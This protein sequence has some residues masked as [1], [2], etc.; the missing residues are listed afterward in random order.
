MAIANSPMYQD[1]TMV[2]G[3]PLDT[4]KVKGQPAAETQEELKRTDPQVQ[5]Q[6]YLEQRITYAQEVRDRNWP[7]FSNKT[8][9]Q[10]YQDNEKIANTYVEPKKNLDEVSLASGTIESKLGTLLSHIDNLNL[11]PEVLA[12]DR[13]DKPLRDLGVAFTD[14]LDKVAEH[15]GGTDGGDSEKRL[16]RQKDLLKQGTVFVQD[17]WC[18]KR[19]AQKTLKAKYKGEFNWDAWDTAWK[20]YYEGPD[21]VLLYGPNVYLGD[22]T[23]FS[24]D[25]QP[26]VFTVETMSYDIARTLFGTF[27][28]WT[29]VKQGM[30]PST[31]TTAA[32]TIGGRTIYDGKFRLTTLKDTQVEVIKYQDPTRDEFQ[33]MINGVMMLPIGFPLS[34]VTPGGKINIAKQILFPINPQFA[35]GK[36]FVASG[37][38]YGLSRQ[39]DEFI[40]L[41]VM[42]TRK[43]ITPAY[44]NMTSKVIS[45]RV[46]SPGN[47]SQ[48]IPPNALLPINGNETQ[49]VTN[50]EFAVYKQMLELM[51]KS[52]I[53]P[54]FQGQYGGSNT[55]ATEVI[56]VQRQARLSIG[57]IITACTLL[58]VKLT[59]LRLP[60]IIAN[61]FEPLEQ[62]MGEDGAT[63]T[64][65]Y[66]STSRETDIEGSGK[67]TRQ[68]IPMD[69]ELPSKQEVRGLE[70]MEEQENGYPVQ[71]IFLSPKQLRKIE[72]TWYV[73]VRP[74]ER[75]KSAY[76]KLLFR[77]MLADGIA[78]FKLGSV[79]NLQGLETQF[80]N[81]YSKDRNSFFGSP[82]DL[83]SPT[84]P[85]SEGNAGGME[86]LGSPS[87]G[88]P[89]A[90]P[91]MTSQ[92]GAG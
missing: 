62:I 81:A 1:S 15:D 58:E 71:K 75:D 45:R 57:T 23:T 82:Q 83:Q 74:Q 70:I 60:V 89:T 86:G 16:L 38:V 50:G 27:E 11:L 12:Y 64:N 56:E 78:L 61:Y 26:Y 28:N 87:S 31:P 79:P 54:A 76:E 85:A 44:I 48:G 42:K 14:I 43:S 5:Y 29:Y 17:K 55:T 10:Y 19:K 72:V 69:G 52:T 8:Y 36:S 51:D 66:R 39:I 80:A 77:E 37:D 20:P 53:G 68:V 32:G 47:I 90:S 88:S 33:I 22:I 30:P 40:R 67:G 59:Y 7:E 35:Y 24:M 4:K 6:S 2:G 34:A 3:D 63:M 18:T 13:D 92:I 84:N 46:L 41:F 65:R 25:E 9:L 73:H 21:R 91:S 49:G